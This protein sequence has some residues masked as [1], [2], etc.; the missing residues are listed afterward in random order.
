MRAFLV[1]ELSKE[2]NITVAEDDL[3]EFGTYHAPA[4]AKIAKPSL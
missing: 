4:P 2:I 3:A 1:R